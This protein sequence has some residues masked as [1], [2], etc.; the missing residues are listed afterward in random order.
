MR[1]RLVVLEK[2]GCIHAV[3]PCWATGRAVETHG[4]HL[5]SRAH[6]EAVLLGGAGSSIPS[7]VGASGVLEGGEL[8]KGAQEAEIVCA[9]PRFVNEGERKG[10]ERALTCQQEMRRVLDVCHGTGFIPSPLPL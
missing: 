7:A 5:E 8:R 10:A 9:P 6:D 4:R 1:L 2:H 3:A